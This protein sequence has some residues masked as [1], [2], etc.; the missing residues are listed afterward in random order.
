MKL[1][2]FSGKFNCFSKLRH[3][4]SFVDWKM[5]QNGEN[6]N[7]RYVLAV[8][9]PPGIGINFYVAF[10]RIRIGLHH[11][12]IWYLPKALLLVQLFTH[13][14]TKGCF[15]FGAIL[16][17]HNSLEIC[18]YLVKFFSVFLSLL[19]NFIRLWSKIYFNW[20]IISKEGENWKVSSS[21]KST[22]L[23]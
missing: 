2:P 13:Q 21:G 22:F 7:V 9:H 18:Y 5:W 6:L 1:K 15:S 3:S 16:F 12:R 11:K 8:L 14:T 4:L 20:R 10:V 19:A 17:S 23:V